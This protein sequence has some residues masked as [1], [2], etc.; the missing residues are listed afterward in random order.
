MF[1]DDASKAIG[2]QIAIEAVPVL[3][4][5]REQTPIRIFAATP[6]GAP[7]VQPAA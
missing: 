7:P 5:K 3:V 4:A 6:Q 2:K 1:G